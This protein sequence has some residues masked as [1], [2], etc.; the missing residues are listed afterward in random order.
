MA[1]NIRCS[2]GGEAALSTKTC[3]RCGEIYPKKGRKYKV[4]VRTANGKKVTKTTT[5]LE[6]ARDLEGQLKVN[7]VRG[8]HNLHKKRVPTLGDV[9]KR[10]EPWAREH[11]K[12]AA[13]DIGYYRRHLQ[14]LF[15]SK[16]LDQISPFDIEKLI[17]TMRRTNSNHGK[18]YAEGTIKHQIVLLSRL[19][20]AALNWGM[21]DGPNPCQKVKKPRLN[22]QVTEYL[23]PD[24]LSRLL[25][26]LEAWPCKVTASFVKFLLFTGLRKG[27][28][29]KL[30]WKDVDIDRKLVFLRDP[31]GGKDQVLPLSDK[32]VETLRSVPRL[33]EIPFIFYATKGG[34]RASFRYPW[35]RIKKAA[36][37]PADFR[38]H[39]L[40][41][42]FASS[43]VSAGVDLFSVSKLLTHKDV[44]TTM[45][46]AHLS[47]QALRNALDVSDQ[48]QSVKA[49]NVIPFAVG[50]KR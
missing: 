20:S 42:H 15:E 27:E 48:C 35:Q 41:H 9:W 46:Y 34:K 10:F 31:K 39:G 28:L 24:E 50:G 13:S 19:Y 5:N 49:S 18:C 44:Q 40:R 11:K 32:A 25:S 21:Y 45:R 22:N 12:S 29:L 43:L 2:C 7:I 26:T 1:I 37:L 6:L 4:T 3:P 8:A 36:G 23:T 30:A 38:L 14:P 33:Q 47:D 16:Q 17:I